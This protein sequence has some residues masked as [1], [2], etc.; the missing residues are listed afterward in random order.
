MELR[1]LRYFVV[2]AEELNFSKAAQ[3]LFI[4]QPTLSL[5]I[6]QLE[7]SLGAKLFIRGKNFKTNQLTTAGEYL[8]PKA[9]ELL[10]MIEEIEANVLHI[11]GEIVKPTLKIGIDD[12]LDRHLFAQTLSRF[13]TAYPDVSLI[14]ETL[15]S[16]TFSDALLK[17]K[18]DIGFT[19]VKP[20]TPNDDLQWHELN[21]LPLCLAVNSEYADAVR[22]DIKTILQEKTLYLVKDPHAQSRILSI[23]AQQGISPNVVTY[24]DRVR[25]LTYVE[26]GLGVTIMHDS[27]I[28]NRTNNGVRCISLAEEQLTIHVFAAHLNTEC[29]NP[30]AAI[31]LSFY[32]DSIPN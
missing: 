8:L 4:S 27:A 24:A 16:N 3:I 15:D 30:H 19:V 32:I 12:K 28:G 25:V 6:S 13:H 22:N 26:A 7:E 31:F 1:Q 29:S 17:K 23:L 18:I 9:K 21:Q 20:D 14:I 11:S 5:S 10:F 2:A